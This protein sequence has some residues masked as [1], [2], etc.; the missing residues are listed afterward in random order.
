MVRSGEDQS[1]A[2][3]LANCNC[4][5]WAVK[6]TATACGLYNSIN[7]SDALSWLPDCTSVIKSGARALFCCTGCPLSGGVSAA[8]TPGEAAKTITLIKLAKMYMYFFTPRIVSIAAR[9]IKLFLKKVIRSSLAA[10]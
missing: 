4:H 3:L 7:S 5:G 8:A 10:F 9:Q 1:F 6:S 2:E